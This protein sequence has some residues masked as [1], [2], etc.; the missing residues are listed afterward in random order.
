M[1]V[2]HELI[3]KTNG[4]WTVKGINNDYYDLDKVTKENFI[5]VVV[6]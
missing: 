6:K 5:G 1:L 3:E 4:E 2:C